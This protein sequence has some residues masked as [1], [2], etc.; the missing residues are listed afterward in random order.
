VLSAETTPVAGL[1][2]QARTLL[3]DSFNPVYQEY[4]VNFA[5][6]RASGY[7]RYIDDRTIPI[8]TVPA[9]VG[10]VSTGPQREIEGAGEFFVTQNWGFS[11]VGIRDLQANQWRQRDIGLVYKD[12]CIR[13]EVFYQHEDVIQSQLG[14]S[15]TVFVRLTLATLGDQ[16]YT[17]AGVH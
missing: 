16:G 12:D 8:T 6:A 1:F 11:L 15:N 2:V 17:Q 7:V 3:T 14:E 5:Y 9:S 13:V 10:L 4:G